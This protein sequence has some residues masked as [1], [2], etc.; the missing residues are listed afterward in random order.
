MTH[1]PMVWGL[2]EGLGGAEWRGAME[3]KLRQL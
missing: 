2:P 1:G 3:E